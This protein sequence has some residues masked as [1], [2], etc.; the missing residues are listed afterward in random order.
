MCYKMYVKWLSVFCFVDLR[1][2]IILQ[3][4]STWCINFLSM[5]IAFLY[6][7]RAIMCPSSGENTVPMR[8][9]V[10]VTRYR[11]LSVMQG[12]MKWWAHSCPK[13]VDKSHKHIKGI[14]APSWFYVQDGCHYFAY[15]ITYDDYN[16]INSY[17][18]MSTIFF[19]I[20]VVYLIYYSKFPAILPY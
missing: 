17:S 18:F 3:I 20:L 2:C 9:L 15:Q 19:Y 14:C 12:G 11:R 6:V 10:L 16:V 7:F 4:E 5:F 8:H 13:Y 1:P